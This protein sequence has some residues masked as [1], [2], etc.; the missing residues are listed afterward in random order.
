MERLPNNI[1]C[2]LLL[3]GLQPQVLVGLF[4][5]RLE[6]LFNH[7]ICL[8]SVCFPDLDPPILCFLLCEQPGPSIFVYV[9]SN[10]TIVSLSVNEYSAVSAIVGDIFEYD[11]M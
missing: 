9:A 5:Y 4:G 7:Y 8:P 11:G 6:Q 2:A 1:V 3:P 10:T